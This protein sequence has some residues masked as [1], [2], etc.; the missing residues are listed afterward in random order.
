M[1]DDDNGI[2]FENPKYLVIIHLSLD[3]G[4]VPS[5]DYGR[6]DLVTKIV[7]KCLGSLSGLDRRYWGDTG[8]VIQ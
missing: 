6:G 8:L 1:S 5:R 4:Q 7:G 2:F 3:I